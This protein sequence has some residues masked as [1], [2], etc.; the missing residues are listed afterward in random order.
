M[1]AGD[2]YGDGVVSTYY[3]LSLEN[4][5][6]NGGRFVERGSKKPSY[7][8]MVV[9]PRYT[10]TFIGEEH[11]WEATVP[12]GC[13]PNFAVDYELVIQASSPK[14][15]WFV[16][17]DDGLSPRKEVGLSTSGISTATVDFVTNPDINRTVAAGEIIRVGWRAKGGSATPEKTNAAYFVENPSTGCTLN[18]TFDSAMVDPDVD[19]VASCLRSYLSGGTP[20]CP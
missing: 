11:F 20:T 19:D 13:D 7:P 10:R 17:H 5:G 4:V 14:F 2:A 8:T 6:T 3:P 12:S 16:E 18:W 1:E 9:E 15:E